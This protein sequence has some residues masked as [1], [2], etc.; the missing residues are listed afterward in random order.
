[1][2]GADRY[3]RDA[4]DEFDARAADAADQPVLGYRKKRRMLGIEIVGEV[5]VRFIARI[6]GEFGVDR[7]KMHADDRDEVFERQRYGDGVGRNGGAEPDGMR[8]RIDRQ[9]RRAEKIGTEH[10]IV[11]VSAD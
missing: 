7:S 3:L 9:A 4:A 8:R 2:I 11:T 5:D 6:D 1:M 10:G